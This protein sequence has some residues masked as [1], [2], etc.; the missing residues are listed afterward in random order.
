[1]TDI[2]ERLLED[3]PPDQADTYP[4]KVIDTYKAERHEAAAMIKRLRDLFK[5]QSGGHSEHIKGLKAQHEAER[6]IVYQ[7]VDR[8]R[9][10]L[11]EAKAVIKPFAAI[12]HAMNKPNE[13]GKIPLVDPWEDYVVFNIGSDRRITK[14]DLRKAAAWLEGRKG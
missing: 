6:E 9:A 4:N 14:G 13:Y 2:V 7:V 1:M 10:E 5:E 8:L 11:A 12:G 3:F